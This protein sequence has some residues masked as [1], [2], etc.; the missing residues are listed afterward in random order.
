MAD[1]IE[2]RTALVTGGGRG[3]GRA[4]A[5]AL[6]RAGAHLVLVGRTAEALD[7]VT[8]EVVDDGGPAPRPRVLDVADPQAIAAA[9]DR[10]RAEDITVDILVNNA[11]VAEAEPLAPTALALSH[12]PLAPNAT[13]PFLLLPP[14]LP[15]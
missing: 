8:R 12:P 4:V 2:G 6:G 1:S 13:P 5:L 11:G 10:L 14:L 3:I 9:L 7:A 15:S